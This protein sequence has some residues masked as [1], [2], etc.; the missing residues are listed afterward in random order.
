MRPNT[1]R[2]DPD[3]ARFCR[4]LADTAAVC[5]DA[6]H[7]LLINANRVRLNLHMPRGGTVLLLRFPATVV[8]DRDAPAIAELLAGR[9]PHQAV[10][11]H[12][13]AETGT[14]D[15]GLGTGDWGLGT[16]KQGPGAGT[17]EPDAG[18]QGPEAGDQEPEAGDQEPEAS[19][20]GAGSSSDGRRNGAGQP[21]AGAPRNGRGRQP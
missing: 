18:N 9:P 6:T 16:G 10:T 2:Y 21:P 20:R 17:Q 15:Q 1:R 3:L 11:I 7:A 14:G 8:V 5:A 19:D 12:P 4:D 13:N